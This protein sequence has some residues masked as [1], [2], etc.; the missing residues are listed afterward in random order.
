[1]LASLLENLLFSLLMY[2]IRKRDF[3]I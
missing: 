2:K 3:V 1:M